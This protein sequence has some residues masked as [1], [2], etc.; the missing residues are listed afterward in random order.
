MAVAVEAAQRVEAVIS[1]GASCRVAMRDVTGLGALWRSQW[2]A[3]VLPEVLKI[4][5][6]QR[7]AA[8]RAAREARLDL[9]ELLG[10]AAGLLLVTWLTR[11]TLDGVPLMSRIEA[12]L[13]NFVV[14]VPLLLVF[15]GP[16]HLR[17]MRRGL[18]EHVKALAPHPSGSGGGHA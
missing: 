7:T 9:I 18:R 8:L 12:A 10:M 13:A 14:A 17:R 11:Y 16:F 1:R 6:A 15:V 3:L 5:P 4:A 2:Y